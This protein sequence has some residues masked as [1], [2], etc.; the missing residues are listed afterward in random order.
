[1]RP[2]VVLAAL[3][4][5]THTF[6][7]GRTGLADCTL[8][9]GRDLLAHAGDP[10]PLA[11]VLEVAA[12]ESW[13]VIPTVALRATPGPIVDD[14][15]VA[16]WWSHLDT[17]LESETDRGIDGVFLVLHGAMVAESFHDVTGEVLTRLRQ[18]SGW[19]RTVIG[20]VLDLHANFTGQMARG[21]DALVSYREN[22][23]ADAKEAAGRAARLLTRLMRSGERP[24]TVWKQTPILWPPTGT[25]TA[26]EPLRSLE[27]MARDME[28]ETPGVLAVNVLPGFAFADVLDAG[29][30]FAAV[31]VGDPAAARRG[32]EQLSEAAWRLRESGNVRDLSVTEFLRC[33]AAHREGPVVA[34]EPSDNIGAGAPGDGTGLLRVLVEQRIPDAVMV[35]NDPVAVAAAHAAGP[36]ARVSLS[37][38][39]KGSSLDPGPLPL[40]VEVV[41]MDDGRFTLEDPRS[42]LA[43]MGGAVVDMGPCAV[44]RHGGV[45]I[46]LTSRRTPPFDLGQLRSQGLDPRAAFVIGVKA[47]VAHRRAYDPIAKA[48]YSVD[49]PGPCASN[50]RTLPYRHV[51]RPIYPLDG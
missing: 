2:R 4:H 46:L 21:A 17:V 33:L 35:I 31:T 14:A 18:R 5:E 13:D 22:P 45:R 23:H 26:A 12:E 34:A 40:E 41:R 8:E 44:V 24:L 37:I 38:G 16:R 20:G 50:L 39:G 15:V 32:L 42:H 25:A 7:A 11:G 29:V 28:P 43:S 6:L 10:S 9:T 49:T 48:H 30:S 3:V 47:A 51:R 36:R 27:A 19:E 1:M